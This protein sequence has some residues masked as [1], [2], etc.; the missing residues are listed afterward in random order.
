VALVPNQALGDMAI[1]RL[2][3]ILVAAAA[4]IIELAGFS[5][6]WI[7]TTERV[8][9]VRRLSIAVVVARRLS[10]PLPRDKPPPDRN[11]IQR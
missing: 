11:R 9:W 5:A 7:L 2:M 6:P 4:A 8:A 3:A 10:P 1:W